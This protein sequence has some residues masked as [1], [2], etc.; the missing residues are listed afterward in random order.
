M[1]P[2]ILRTRR[3]VADEPHSIDQAATNVAL[4]G[5]LSRLGW[6]P[7]QFTRQ[8]NGLAR[9]LRL[10]VPEMHPK[11]PRRWLAARPPSTRPC[12]PRQPWPG[13][14][15]ALLSRHLQESVTLASLG[16]QTSAGALYVPADDGL[17]HPWDPRGAIVSLREVLEAM[18]MDRRHFVVLTGTGL[19]AFAH[20]WLLDPERVATSVQGKR[21]D[22]AVVDDLER[23]ADAR[24][25][26]NDALGG[27]TM[28][29][30][31]QEDLRLI[32]GMLDNASYTED[33]GKR[34]YAVAAEFARLAGWLAYDSNQ[35][36]LAQRYYMAGLRAAHSSGDR[37]I[38]ANI[39]G[40]MSIQAKYRD[41]RDAVRMAESALSRA[42]ELT[43]AMVASL[44]GRLTISAACAGDAATA[45]RAQGR[46]FE[47]MTAIDPAVEPPYMYWW[48]EAEAHYFAGQSA[49]AR[50]N[51]RD[52]E[53]H[54]R[55]AIARLDPS[56]VR[57]RSSWLLRLATARVHLRELDGAFR[58]ATEAAALVRRLDSQHNLTRLAEF[59]K[60]VQLYANTT[61]VKDF[62]TKFGDLLRPTSA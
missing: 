35:E 18:G 51:P 19:T 3:S 37:A 14:V 61:Q 5:Y 24:R 15:C 53:T 50:H 17:D 26:L 30:A 6:T 12:V 9:S 33:V 34:L 16:W 2:L 45:E 28:F 10:P 49:F 11:T 4:I 60:A 43:P 39:L 56:F 36:A 23:V 44:Q 7:E 57:D 47:F 29:R 13:L 54:Y 31:V 38:G 25:R 62:D 46:M 55:T 42:E 41:P 1:G 27:G 20:D 58:A 22:H 32:T 48:S 8:L 59:R 21:V 52:A 40:F